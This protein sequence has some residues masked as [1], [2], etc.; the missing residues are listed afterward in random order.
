MSTL[1]NLVVACS[2]SAGL[3]IRTNISRHFKP[4][5]KA[6]VL[7]TC[8]AVVSDPG[9]DEQRAAEGFGREEVGGSSALFRPAVITFA[10]VVSTVSGEGVDSQGLAVSVS[11]PRT[12][13]YV[14]VGD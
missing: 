3:I 12:K 9:R 13:R 2:R 7:L 1:L 4:K 6:F 8:L 14:S 10:R 5:I 11:A